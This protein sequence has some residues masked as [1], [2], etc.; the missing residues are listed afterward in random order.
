MELPNLIFVPL[1]LYYNESMGL[2][3]KTVFF[4]WAAQWNYICRHK[5]CIY[6]LNNSTNRFEKLAGT[7]W[8]SG[9]FIKNGNDFSL[10]PERKKG[11]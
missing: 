4:Q 6:I 11:Y 10:Y 1:L 5:Q 7:K 8:Q 3:A 9:G 2:P